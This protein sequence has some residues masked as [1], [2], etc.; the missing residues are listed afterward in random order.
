LLKFLIHRAFPIRARLQKYLAVNQT[1]SATDTAELGASVAEQF[2]KA[3]ASVER[4]L[5]N[6]NSPDPLVLAHSRLIASL[7]LLSGWKPDRAKMLASQ[8]ASKGYFAGEV[9]GIRLASQD[10][11]SCIP[12]EAL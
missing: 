3:I 10:G 7:S 4:Q 5:S 8:L 12:F 6:W 2:G 9:A 11:T 1:L